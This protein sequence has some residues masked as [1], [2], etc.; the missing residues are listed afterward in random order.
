MMREFVV[1]VVNF[2]EVSGFEAARSY[3]GHHSHVECS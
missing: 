1:G 3:E 2:E